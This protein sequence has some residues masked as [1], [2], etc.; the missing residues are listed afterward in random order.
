MKKTILFTILI[1]S[2]ALTGCAIK[3]KV[4]VGKNDQ[5]K[6][7][8]TAEVGETADTSASSV[9]TG[10]DKIKVFNISDN[11]TVYSPLT[12]SGKASAEKDVL[13]VEL[14]NSKH[15]PLVKESTKIKSDE[16]GQMGD[17]SITLNFEFNNTKEG[18][19]AVYEQGADGSE[20]NLVEIPV[21]FGAWVTYRNEKWGFT[22][23]LPTLI[24]KDYGNYSEDLSLKVFDMGDSIAI[25]PADNSKE[26]IEKEIKKE[27]YPTWN[28]VSANVNNEQE[29]EKFVKDRFGGGCSSVIT[30]ANKTTYDVEAKFERII[31]QPGY[32]APIKYSPTLKR[33]V[34]WIM[35]QD[36][37]WAVDL[38]NDGKVLTMGGDPGNPDYYKECAD[39]IIKDSFAFIE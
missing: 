15:E 16:A 24:S 34:T 37:S 35:G 3:K 27:S 18:F 19:V 22:L 1:V 25:R 9:Q 30:Q 8:D 14:R 23:K 28:L 33:I 6:F 4:E 31:C 13:I 2:L 20:L 17:Y 32:W 26:E 12:V 38:D 7:E 5:A 11:Q 39:F 36:C 29:L 21:K 10:N